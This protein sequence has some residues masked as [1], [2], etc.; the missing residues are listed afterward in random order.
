MHVKNCSI[1]IK[2]SSEDPYFIKET[3]YYYISHSSIESQVLGYLY[4]EPKRHIEHW[5]ELYEEEF[6]DLSRIIK[7]IEN[8]LKTYL[9]AERIYLVTISETVR[10][11]HYHIIPRTKD[12]DLKGAPLIEQ[13]TTQNIKSKKTITAHQISRLIE[14]LKKNL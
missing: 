2:H 8:Q 6:L 9:N 5:N 7:N 1:C 12:Y 11:I 3:Q 10:H 13:A 14:N 4:I